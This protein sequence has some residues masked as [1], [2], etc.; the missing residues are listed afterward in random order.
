MSSS[1][2]DRSFAYKEEN[3]VTHM[4]LTRVTDE[5]VVLKDRC[6]ACKILMLFLC[7]VWILFAML[8]VS[9][10]SGANPKAHS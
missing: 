6:I 4:D 5:T 2:G 3:S 8:T 10:E 7:F 9:L 1:K